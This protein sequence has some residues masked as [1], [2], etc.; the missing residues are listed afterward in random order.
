MTEPCLL[1][2]DGCI[3]DCN[4][5]ALTRFGYTRENLIGK[6]PH[7]LFS[8]QDE[9]QSGGHDA[10]PAFRGDSLQPTGAVHTCRCATIEG[11]EFDARLEISSL[12]GDDQPGVVVRVQEE[13]R[14][15]LPTESPAASQV[16]Q[17]EARKLESLGLMAGGLAHDFNNFLLAILGNADLLDRDLAAGKPGTELLNEIRKAASRAADLCNQLL[18]YSGKGKTSF[19]PL[20][21]SLTLREMLPMLKVAIPRTIA[22]RLDLADNLP[23]IGGDL[24]QIHQMVMNLIVNASEAIGSESGIITLAT[25]RAECPCPK[26]ASCLVGESR[27]PNNHVYLEVRDT[28]CGMSNEIQ[29]RLFDPYFST[30]VRG[31][32]QGLTTVLGSVRSHQGSLCVQSVPGQGTAVRACLPVAHL[33]E[34]PLVK[35]GSTPRK[36]SSPGSI[37][38]VD[39]EEYLRLLCSRMLQRLGYSVIL[40]QDGPHALEI[41]C[42]RRGLI[43][44][45]ILDLEMPVM[46]GIE[47]LEKLL[48]F[49]PAAR[50]IMTSGYHEREIAARFSGRGISGFIQKPYVMSDLG[51]VLQKIISNPG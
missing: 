19:Q 38:I 20:D 33:T 49:D 8:F 27:R 4:T 13:E 16:V 18:I 46:D 40:A 51:Q 36:A 43:D 42:E 9:A 45:V 31:R 29:G 1:I 37:L 28:G 11:E 15:A 25:G 22:L 47:V 6:S 35:E 41:Y 7:H 10:P 2:R 12:V 34:A 39:D 3:Q 17:E 32:G 48:D 30:K 26:A 21:L 14:T 24:G 44:G 23:L 50:V 5:P